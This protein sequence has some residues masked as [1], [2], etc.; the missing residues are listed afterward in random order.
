MKKKIIIISLISAMIL[1]SGCSNAAEKIESNNSVKV[2]YN[3]EEVAL[4]AEPVNIDGTIMVPMR[5][6]FEKAGVNVKWDSETQTVSAKKKS[7]DY[8]LAIGSTTIT[9]SKNDEVIDTV[10]ALQESQVIDGRTM[11]PLRA[12]GEILGLD[13][14]WD[15]TS[16]TVSLTDS[17]ESADESWKENQGTIALDNMNV[18]GSGITVSDNVVTITGGGD[19]TVTGECEN[20]QIVVNT[21]EKV[22]LRLNGMSLTNKSGA[23]IYVEDADKLYITLESG[24]ENNLTDSGE[25]SENI[26]ADG[27]LYSKDSVE[28]KGSGILNINANVYHGIKVKNSLEISNGTINI[29]SVGDGIHVNDTCDIIGGTINI[30]S[31]LDG[32]QADDILN[33]SKG[34]INVTCTGE[35]SASVASM[36]MGG[37]RNRMM[38]QETTDTDDEES[39]EIS[40]KGLKAGWMMN[41][42][43]GNINIKSNDTCIKCDS[44]LNI[45]GG[46]INLYSENKKGIK[47]MEDVNINDGV[48][49]IEKSSEGIESKRVL[50]VNGGK[51]DLV[52]SD[53][54]FNAGGSSMNMGGGMGRQEMN[55]ADGTKQRPE[56]TDGAA[57]SEKPEKTD[58]MTPLQ[59]PD[60]ANS[61]QGMHMGVGFGRGSAEISTEHH[62]EIN[63]GEI[64]INAGG[65]GID[66]NGS[67]VINGGTVIVESTGNG[68]S[69]FDHDGLFEING[70]TAIGFGTGGMIE[71]PSETSKQNVLSV[72]L[73]SQ[74]GAGSEIE[75]KNSSGKTIYTFEPSISG[76]HIMFSSPDVE[77][78][79][80]YTVYTDGTAQNE[81]AAEV[82][83]ALTIIG[84]FNGMGGNRGN[85]GGKMNMQPDSQ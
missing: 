62:I 71:N 34:D 47:G 35:V 75:I 78:G 67:L 54:G 29:N 11:I 82:T 19:F 31:A 13:V 22:K 53:D 45:N 8:S 4:D 15:E 41:I 56:R 42:T 32:I 83:G 51:I 12:L 16:Q 26:D 36:G 2:L 64:K 55:T 72:Y 70:G 43:G 65:D 77:S 21:K 6:I 9:K 80:S 63:G 81:T 20:G 17:E 40:S 46:E 52:S 49:N 7:N 38:I 48:I 44:E 23:P 79:N 25:Y 69:A 61:E 37:G 30:T 84:G 73:T 3:G 33:I 74:A 39:D 18:T 59:M 85:R 14:D 66:S 5:A 58:Q 60:T 68:D 28:I 27:C 76:S 24:T 10:E 50:T 57:M 1:A